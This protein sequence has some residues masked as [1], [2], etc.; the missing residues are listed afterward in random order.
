MEYKKPSYEN[1]K[2]PEKNYKM[3]NSLVHILNNDCPN[4]LKGKVFKEKA[5]LF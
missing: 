1:D 2:I 3:S 4:C 5:S